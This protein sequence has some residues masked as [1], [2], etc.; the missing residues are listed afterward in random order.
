MGQYW[1]AV[2][3]CL[4]S[5]LQHANTR[6]GA[7]RDSLTHGFPQ[8]QMLLEASLDRTVR[9]CEAPG[10]PVAVLPAQRTALM[11]ALAPF[12]EASMSGSLARLQEAAAVL[13]PTGARSLPTSAAV[14]QY[15]R[16]ALVR[17]WHAQVLTT[18]H[19]AILRMLALFH[20]TSMSGSLARLQEAAVL[21][22]TGAR[23]LPTSAIM[24]QYIR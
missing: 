1:V 6:G 10:A 7:V 20:E 3:D 13:Y 16:C 24:Q 2:G 9:E 11:R 22:P 8:L 17:V 18:R 14:Q 21:Y 19:A 5:A 23:S 15:I 4:A 12:R